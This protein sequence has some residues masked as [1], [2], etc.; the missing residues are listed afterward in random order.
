MK[1]DKLRALDSGELQTQLRD[2]AEQL[3]HLRLQLGMGHADG[4][5]K[6]RGLK[7]DRARVLTILRER[8]LAPEPASGKAAEEE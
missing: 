3:Y 5:K 2:L 7:K 4:L 8:E 6:Y 1:A